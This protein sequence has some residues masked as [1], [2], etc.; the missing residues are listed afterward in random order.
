MQKVERPTNKSYYVNFPA[1]IAEATTIEKGETMEWLIE[2][3][4]TFIL[5]RIKPRKSLLKKK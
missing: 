2:D 5:R 3:Q 4:N 1:A